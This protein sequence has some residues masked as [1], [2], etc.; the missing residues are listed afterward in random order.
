M[1]MELSVPVVHLDKEIILSEVSLRS[2]VPEKNKYLQECKRRCYK[3][4]YLIIITTLIVIGLL[5]VIVYSQIISDKYLPAVCENFTYETAN[6]TEEMS[7]CL[8][9]YDICFTVK[10]N[11][12][13]KILPRSDETPIWNS[14]PQTGNF[15]CYMDDEDVLVQDPQ[16]TMTLLWSIIPAMLLLFIICICIGIKTRR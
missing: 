8:Q 2:D 5:S 11:G 15:T 4:R 12:L 13:L 9:T 3:S 16:I 1:A 6:I 10:I 7:N 14:Y